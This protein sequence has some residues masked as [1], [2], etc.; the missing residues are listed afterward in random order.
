MS[1]L[2]RL[3]EGY[4]SPMSVPKSTLMHTF[5]IIMARINAPP[6]A[7]CSPRK[8]AGDCVWA[9]GECSL[10][11]PHLGQTLIRARSAGD[12]HSPRPGS[13]A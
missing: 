12:L 8:G 9:K 10:R 5:G 7:R 2:A 1:R 4:A 3:A 13:A 6:P 11:A